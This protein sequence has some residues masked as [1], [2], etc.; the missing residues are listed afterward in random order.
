MIFGFACFC[1]HD[2]FFALSGGFSCLCAWCYIADLD[3]G[4]GGDGGS[5]GDEGFFIVFVVVGVV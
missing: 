5:G 1:C 2:F 3:G 4:D